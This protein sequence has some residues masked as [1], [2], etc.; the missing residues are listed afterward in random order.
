MIKMGDR[1][2]TVVMVLCYKL[3]GRWLDPRWSQ[4]I[5]H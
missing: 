5:F 4:W 1:G 3:E 2:S